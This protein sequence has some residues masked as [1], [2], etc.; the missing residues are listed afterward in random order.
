MLQRYLDPPRRDSEPTLQES[1]SVLATRF[2]RIAC[3]RSLLVLW[4]SCAG[5][6]SAVVHVVHKVQ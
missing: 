3:H 5:A 4:V 2:F 1:S 6:R